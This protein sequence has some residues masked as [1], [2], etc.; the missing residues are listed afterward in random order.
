MYQLSDEDQAVFR[1]RKVVVDGD[2]LILERTRL[3]QELNGPPFYHNAARECNRNPFVMAGIR[4]L[5][6]HR[7]IKTGGRS[8]WFSCLSASLRSK[9]QRLTVFAFEY[10]FR[11]TVNV[12]SDTNTLGGLSVTQHDFRHTVRVHLNRH[13]PGGSGGT[14]RDAG[15]TVLGADLDAVTGGLIGYEG[16]GSEILN[17][18]QANLGLIVIEMDSMGAVSLG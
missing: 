10:D 9:H 18:A 2:C 4:G 15:V 6:G 8:L 16:V 14:N 17:N 1:I 7:S 12:E 11:R 13:P 3:V 5:T